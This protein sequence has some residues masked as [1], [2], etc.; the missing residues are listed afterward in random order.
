MDLSAPY[1]RIEN[2][3]H[4]LDNDTNAVV[5]IISLALNDLP[6]MK[7]NLNEAFRSGDLKN[8]HFYAHKLKSTINLF[9]IFSIKP[10]ILYLEKGKTI[11]KSKIKAG[12]ALTKINFV[13]NE[14]INEL[15]IHKVQLNIK[16]QA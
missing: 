1:T 16:S 15:I 8:I 4:L 6:V 10:E 9:E 14:S 3:L 2:I 7:A 12:K 5:K 13:L 11:L